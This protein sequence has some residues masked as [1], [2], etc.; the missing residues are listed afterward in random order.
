MS[1][2]VL[3]SSVLSFCEKNS[4]Y[5]KIFNPFLEEKELSSSQRDKILG[6]LQG[7]L[8]DPRFTK[9]IAECFSHILLILLTSA[10]PLNEEKVNDPKEADLLHRINCSILG[11]LVHEH[12]DVLSP[13]K[14]AKNPYLE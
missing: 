8:K 6:I 13:N 2:T 5:R 14:S 1:N 9:D 12:P 10:I 7:L 3:I 11:K 4:S